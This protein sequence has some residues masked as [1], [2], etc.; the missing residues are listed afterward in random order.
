MTDLGPVAQVLEPGESIEVVARARSH[1]IVV[2]N[3][4]LAV[5]DEHRVALHISF[6]SLRRI[7]FDI[8]RDRPA[9]LVIVPE[10]AHDEPQVLAVAVDQY[11][12]VARA[13]VAIGRRLVESRAAT[14]D[15]VRR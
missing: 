4:R 1:Q 10:H 7:Q 3:Q 8:E 14:S 11:E 13:L 9:T 2:T 5:A 6:P 15:L 12:E